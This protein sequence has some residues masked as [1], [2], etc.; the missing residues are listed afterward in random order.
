M[1]AGVYLRGGQ[2]GWWLGG[3]DG[4]RPQYLVGVA[5]PQNMYICTSK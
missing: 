1:G 5:A 2:A 4:T 3:G